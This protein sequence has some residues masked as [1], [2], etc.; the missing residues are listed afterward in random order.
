M[1]SS[2]EGKKKNIGTAVISIVLFAFTASVAGAADHY[3][4][5]EGI[6]TRIEDAIATGLYN[7]EVQGV[8][9]WDHTDEGDAKF[10]LEPRIE[11]GI[12]RNLEA[13]LTVPFN[14][15]PGAEDEGIGDVKLGALYNFNQETLV[16]PMF[17]LSAAVNFPTSDEGEGYDTTV[18]AIMTKTIGPGSLLQRLHLNI[19]WDHNDDAEEDER[20]DHFTYILGYD[21]RISP[22]MIWIVDLLRE[23]EKMKGK[24]SNILE[25]GI[26]YML[27]PLTVVAAG[28][29]AGLGDDSPEFRATFG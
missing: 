17:A 18:K 27:N 9:R 11:A 29:G 3:N 25:S 6:P 24:D 28:I 22:D 14:L 16:L 26:R 13:E 7:R 20:D 23:E 5:E 8:F 21:R 12:F 1:R 15:G 2:D 10:L 19:I 4:L